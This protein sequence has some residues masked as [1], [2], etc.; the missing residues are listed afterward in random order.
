MA[1]IYPTKANLL[2]TKKSLELAQMGYELM[3][4]KRNILVR[5]MMLLVDSASSV[6]SQ[7]D[8][9]YKKAYHYLRLAN[10]TIGDCESFAHAVPIDNSLS[11]DFKSVMGVEIPMTSIEE[12]KMQPY[13]GFHHTNSYLDMAYASFIE[14]K[15][16]TVRLA[17]IESGVYRL[18][19]SIKKTRKRANALNNIII[20]RFRQ[21]IKY[22]SDVL[23]EK[24]REDYS[25]LKVIKSKKES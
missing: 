6:R 24:E 11:I 21:T 4:Q 10:T 9:K 5:E 18:A 15:E 8:E 19:D 7:I 3:D 16:L 13:F 17:E 25:R 12:T 14:A 23:D 1:Q 2:A 22:I 20:P